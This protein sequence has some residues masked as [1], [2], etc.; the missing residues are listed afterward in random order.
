VTVTIKV[1]LTA[2]EWQDIVGDMRFFGGEPGIVT[3]E[4]ANQVS[5]V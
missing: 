5:Q 1:P 4:K 2:G 3:L